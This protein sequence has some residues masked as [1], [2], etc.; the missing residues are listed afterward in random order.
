MF[1]LICID[2]DNGEFALYLNDHYLASEDGSGEKLYLGDLM[3]RLS[4][5]PGVQYAK[6]ERSLP[7]DEDWCWIA[8][9]VLLSHQWPSCDTTT[10]GLIKR[11]LEY[12]ENTPCVGSYWLEEDFLVLN[13]E[14]TPEDIQL[15]MQIAEKRHDCNIG[16]N[17]D[18]IQYC[19]DCVK[20][21]N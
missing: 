21:S 15:A 2:L 20:A 12:P 16:Y 8:D 19:I 5:V 1:R 10:G 6:V 18:F 14:L 9:D 13:E 11:L 4:R 17:W 3:E 7:A